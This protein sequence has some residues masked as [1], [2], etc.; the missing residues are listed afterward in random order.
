MRKRLGRIRNG[1][2]KEIDKKGLGKKK[3]GSNQYNKT[4]YVGKIKFPHTG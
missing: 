2:R 3:A 1:V 4:R